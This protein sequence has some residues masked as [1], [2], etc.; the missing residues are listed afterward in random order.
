M[1]KALAVSVFVLALPSIA[2]AQQQ[3]QQPQLKAAPTGPATDKDAARIK[4]YGALTPANK[5]RVDG[6]IAILIGLMTQDK[7]EDFQPAFV[8]EVKKAFPKADEKQID[9]LRDVVIL[10]LAK[11]LEDRLGERRARA[12]VVSALVTCKKDNACFEKTTGA[13]NR[14]KVAAI[15]KE[16]EAKVKD[17]EAE[18]RMGNFEIQRLM[19]AYNQAETLRSS[20]QKKE[21][22]T[23]AAVL[24]KIG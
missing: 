11:Q 22:D 18:D 3:Q 15:R 1:R 23:S 2:F 6:I 19:S 5:P 13:M 20:V 7:A 16:L 4:L 14:E 9:A 24:G 17:L 10:Q 21:A 12:A 8:R